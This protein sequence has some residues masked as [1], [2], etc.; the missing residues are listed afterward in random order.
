[1]LHDSMPPQSPRH[2]PH[3]ELPQVDIRAVAFHRW[4]TLKWQVSFVE[5]H[6]GCPRQGRARTFE[7]AVQ[8]ARTW[9]LDYRAEQY[10]GST[11]AADSPRIALCPWDVRKD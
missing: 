3:D 10:G 6:S 11:F 4:R 5:P 9:S 7:A 2:F 1:M 8:L